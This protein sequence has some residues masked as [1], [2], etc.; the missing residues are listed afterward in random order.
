MI[1]KIFLKYIQIKAGGI[2]L[3]AKLTGVSIKRGGDK[4]S[5]NILRHKSS[6]KVPIKSPATLFCDRVLIK[7]LFNNNRVKTQNN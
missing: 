1:H 3:S 4:I 6:E 7:H 2:L 5:G